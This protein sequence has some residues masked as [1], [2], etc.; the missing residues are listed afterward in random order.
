MRCWLPFVALALAAT[1][2][3]RGTDGANAQAP[4]A[5]VSAPQLRVRLRGLRADVPWTDSLA[6]YLD[7]DDAG[8]RRA[9]FAIATVQAG[10]ATFA[11][12]DWAPTLATK[13]RVVATD[14]NY[15]PL[16]VPLVAP[17]DLT[18]ELVVDV[19]VAAVLAG[20]VVD[21]Q[22]AGV[23]AA[24]VTVYAQRDGVPSDGE[25][26]H[27]NTLPDGR[28]RVQVPASPSLYVL[29]VAMTAADERRRADEEVPDDGELRG[30][31]LPAATTGR[32]ALGTT[33]TVA[34][35]VLPAALP[36]RGA[37]RWSD[38]APF[39][40]ATVQVRPR[41][42][43]TLTLAPP[44]EV[45]PAMALGDTFVRRHDD[46][47]LSPSAR[48]RTGDDGQF[49]LP[50]G[51][52]AVVDV[53]L[54]DLGD[55]HEPV[56]LAPE[57]LQPAA[58]GGPVTFVLPRPV[59]LRARL[60]EEVAANVVFD[61]VDWDAPLTDGDGE[62]LVVPNRSGRVRVQRDG[63]RSAWRELTPADA[64]T[65]V[66]L[67]LLESPIELRL[68][69][70]DEPRVTAASLAWRRIDGSTGTATATAASDGALLA[71]LPPGSYELEITPLGVADQQYVVATRH[72]VVLD[73]QPVDLP[74][75]VAFGGLFTVTATDS[76]GNHAAGTAVLLG[77]DG[78]DR[79]GTF[80]VGYGDQQRH[81]A[82]GELLANGPN[83]SERALPVGDYDLRG[84]F[85]GHA[86]V[87]QRV[88]IA[89]RKVTDVYLRLP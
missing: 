57:P 38:G 7:G 6:L 32:S 44:T 15:H 56:L 48:A 20:R 72:E 87:Q 34:D 53:R 74:L 84:E 65:T 46:G 22:G 55:E 58:P 2:S 17:F 85:A 12:P 69:F 81:G 16:H 5:N 68:R 78:Q 27:T 59:L 63:L 40:G 21:A 54:L 9:L 89:S 60:G 13:G 30:E 42:G 39:A 23:P 11:L 67:Q 61:G 25:L 62:L 19:E 18:R 73:E 71:A 8:E 66:D 47:R 41:D 76:G 26:A 77:P 28:W 14:P 36:L 43:T 37:V 3:C 86:P 75:A 70:A 35:L 88:R 29:A 79:T 50:I 83:R 82:P 31:W 33:T 45:A 4:A 52:G 51:N 80:V 49:V 64:G 1:P 10:Q 24:R